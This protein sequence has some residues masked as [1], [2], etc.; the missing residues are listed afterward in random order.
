MRKET[1]HAAIQFKGFNAVTSIRNRFEAE[2]K[3][4]GIFKTFPRKVRFC[5]MQNWAA[6]SDQCGKTQPFVMRRE[7]RADGDLISPANHNERKKFSR[8]LRP[9]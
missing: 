2:N 5:V 8:L 1:V 3:D 6:A 4:Q 9:S 7:E